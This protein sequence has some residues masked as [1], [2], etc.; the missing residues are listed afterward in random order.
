MARRYHKRHHSRNHRHHSHHH[1][2]FNVRKFLGIPSWIFKGIVL[3]IIGVLLMRFS[4]TIFIDWFNFVEG[5][6]WGFALGVIL[7]IAG[8]FCFIAWWR[9]NILQHRIGLKVGRW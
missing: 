8:I 6:F 5:V 9:N 7:V 1:R 2:K 3:V 4:A